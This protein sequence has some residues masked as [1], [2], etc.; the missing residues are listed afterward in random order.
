MTRRYF[1]WLVLLLTMSALHGVTLPVELDASLSPNGRIRLSWPGSAG[2]VQ[3]E[4]TDELGAAWLPTEIVPI[5]TGEDRVVEV[6][7]AFVAQYFRLR[8]LDEAALTVESTSPATGEGGVAVTRETVVRLSAALAPDTVFAPGQLVAVGGGRKVLSRVEIGSDRRTVSLFYLE[9]LPAGARIEVTFDGA[10]LFDEL[11][12]PADLDGDGIAGGSARVSFDTLSTTAI[13]ATG[14]EGRVL[15]SESP[16]A[17]G[18]IPLQGVTISVDGMEETLRTTTDANGFFRLQP[19]PAGRFF[20][21]VDGRTAVGSQWPGGAYYPFVGKAWDAVP[22]KTNN[23]AGGNGLIYLPL[24]TAS[25]LQPVS[26]TQDTAVRFAADVVAANPSLAGVEINVPANSLFA[27]SGVRGG[28]V[29]MAPVPPDR[30]PEPLPP[31]LNLPLVITIQTDGAMNFDRPVPVKFPNLPDPVT[32][33]KLGPG[34]KSAIWS[35]NHDTGRWEI[36]GPATVTPDGNYVVSDPGVGVRQPGWHGAAPGTSGSGPEDESGEAKEEKCDDLNANGTCDKD[37]DDPCEKEFVAMI[38]SVSDCVNQQLSPLFSPQGAAAG[39]A[40]GFASGITQTFRDCGKDSLS[41][42]KC[43]PTWLKKTGDFTVGCLAGMLPAGKLKLIADLAILAD[44]CY[45]GPG[46]AYGDL[47]NCKKANGLAAGRPA[48]AG[49]R[50]LGPV[51]G[52]YATAKNPFLQQIEIEV[53][54]AGV[55]NLM[56]ASPKWTQ[57]QVEDAPLIGPLVNAASAAAAADSDGGVAL[58]AAEVAATLA[59]PRPRN[60]T[61][62]DVD[63]MLRRFHAMARA[64]LPDAELNGIALAAA[65]ERLEAILQEVSGEGWSH[66]FEGYARIQT[67]IAGLSKGLTTVAAVLNET[68]DAPVRSAMPQGPPSPHADGVGAREYVVMPPGAL[69]YL[70]QDL[71]TG[72]QFRGRLSAQGRFNSLILAP[73]RV[74]AVAYFDPVSRRAGMSFFR[75]KAAGSTTQVPSARLTLGGI[76][77][78]SD[79]LSRLVETILGTD[80]DMADT[81]GDGAGDGAEIAAGTPPRDGEPLS[82]GVVA[83]RDTG[84]NAIDITT[85]DDLAYIADSKGGIAIFNVLNP[86]A[87]TLAGQFNQPNGT[88]EAIAVAGDYVLVEG[89]GV[90]VWSGARQGSLLFLGELKFTDSI[91]AVAAAGRFGYVVRRRGSLSTIA[92]IRLS[93]PSL[94][95]EIEIPGDNS[96]A[97]LKI[98][99]DRLWVLSLGKLRAFRIDGNDLKFMGEAAVSGLSIAPLEAGL[100][101][102]LGVGRAWVGGFQGFHIYDTSNPAMPAFLSKP[103]TT[104]A[105]IH[106]FASTGGPLIAA[107]TS[108]GGQVSLA[109]SLYDVRADRPNDFLASWNTPGDPRALTVHRG[110]ALVADDEA[111][112][113]VVS[114]AAGDR[115]K[116]APM[117]SLRAFTTHPPTGQEADDPFFVAPVVA[118]DVLVRDVEFH[119]D[120]VSAGRSGRHPYAT[121]LRAPARLNGKTNFKLRAR[122][123]DTAGNSAWSDEI[124]LELL[125]DLTPPRLLA[126]SPDDGSVSPRG[127]LSQLTASFD[128]AMNPASLASAWTLVSAGPDALIGTPD[129]QAVSGGSVVVEPVSRTATLGFPAPLRSGSYRARITNIAA[130]LAGNGLAS[131]SAWNFTIPVTKFVASAPADKSLQVPGTLGRVKVHFDERLLPGSVTAASLRLIELGADGLAGTP[132]DQPITGT[133]GI[134]SDG[135]G[136]L[137]NLSRALPDGRYQITFTTALHDAYD[138]PVAPAPP[139]VFTVKAETE[140]IVDASGT[141]E[142]GANWNIGARPPVGDNVVI[143]RPAGD[144]T[145]TLNSD[146]TVARLRSTEAFVLKNRTLTV[147]SNAVFTSQ[148]TLQD[149][150]LLRSTG[151]GVIEAAGGVLLAGIANKSFTDL[152]FRNGGVFDWRGGGILWRQRGVS[153]HNLPGSVFLINKAGPPADTSGMVAGTN[154]EEVNGTFLNDGIL[155]KADGDHAAF[156][157]GFELQNRHRIEV[158]HGVFETALHITNSGVI[159]VGP[160]ARFESGRNFSKGWFTQT[161]TGAITGGGDA[162]LRG[163]ALVDGTVDLGGRLTLKNSYPFLTPLKVQV[164][165]PLK[166]GGLLLEPG[167]PAQLHNGGTV[168]FGGLDI[169]EGLTG[170]GTVG[171]S[172]PTR[173]IGGKIGGSL[174]VQAAGGLTTEGSAVV[175]DQS[176]LVVSGS[177]QILNGLGARDDGVIELL[178]D[179][180]LELANNVGISASR[181]GDQTAQ[182]RNFGVIRKLTGTGMS[183]LGGRFENAGLVR[184]E[185]GTMML[186]GC[187]GTHTGRF[188]T[189]PGVDLWVYG[190]ENIFAAASSLGGVSR[191]VFSGRTGLPPIA[192]LNGNW[193]GPAVDISGS[194]VRVTS[195]A[196]LPELVLGASGV[197]ETDT[198]L[199]V[200]GPLT[201]TGGT[202]RR[203]PDSDGAPPVTLRSEGTAEL[204]PLTVGSNVRVVN[205]GTATIPDKGAVN[206]GAGSQDLENLPG[207]T[208]RLFGTGNLNGQ[209]SSGRVLNAGTLVK[210]APAGISSVTAAIENTGLIELRA[211][212]MQFSR[213]VTQTAGEFRLSGGDARLLRNAAGVGVVFLHLNGGALTGTGTLGYDTVTTATLV[214][215]RAVIRPGLPL[216]ILTLNSRFVQAPT[217]VLEVEIGGPVAGSGHDQLAI[218][219]VAT[220]GG[221]LRLALRDGFAPAIGQEFVVMTCGSRN[222]TPFTTV[223]GTAIGA[224]RKFIVVYENTRVLVR[225]VSGP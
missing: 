99:G 107:V 18:N 128:S 171:V 115:G 142:S 32:G 74:Y 184:A 66:T 162:A 192:T 5:V 216:G 45:L 118:D 82:L 101:L 11:N 206:L 88:A 21:H 7:A 170:A 144:F 145:V 143:D 53:A 54:M 120:G 102:E 59:L 133:P 215:N 187:Y 188:E 211:G 119:I 65:A 154:Y 52:G 80:A 4:I 39:C 8:L 71:S 175:E 75:S 156:F 179:A 138:S 85:Q 81:D 34:E 104:Q 148:L 95:R 73:R 25:A 77:A 127:S 130:D 137:L 12:R 20:V 17:Q 141:W 197:L 64:E 149:Q 164:L 111:G 223:E 224:D 35:F 91:R 62:N 158:T 131:E 68:P 112:L 94:E 48:P 217:G 176:R 98:D 185:A 220:L 198:D 67:I 50:P 210:D 106:S 221:T 151:G 123:T 183:R 92:V 180:S 51:V 159:H 200:T 129:D 222:N 166:V 87:P 190:G 1:G 202:L 19:A 140:W 55:L 93:V 72:F 37:E 13:G 205:A 23:L 103:S 150:A 58:T 178:A 186:D 116:I 126:F 70:I 213:H 3:L 153:F 14:V 163:I 110:Y 41:L 97:A 113:A 208:L 189:T 177:A 146:A 161:A 122:A 218:T 194:T 174:I 147:L 44:S 160:G 173:I 56:F 114:I 38:N 57:V 29:G 191:L 28:R 84:G 195:P 15:T 125:P 49:P 86:L 214:T 100:R 121:T 16:P 155:R 40:L 207:A 63:A 22:G 2:P 89:N 6:P 169:H 124:T 134:S 96:V 196:Q 61:A 152:S 30:L 204:R 139:V 109:V 83:S 212:T 167:G 203:F 60:L 36:A 181:S 10:G 42:Q 168:G 26:A 90:Q 135:R 136:A 33:E 78:D 117:I 225:C 27:E 209:N 46:L 105:A 132:D 108:F 76:D 9:P 165:K 157:A 47:L 69:F 193:T 172:G 31:G 199:T 43:G 79:G 24:V 219:S 201:A 182:V